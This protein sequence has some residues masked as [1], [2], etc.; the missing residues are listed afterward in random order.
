M[1]NPTS[2]SSDDAVAVHG[3]RDTSSVIAA[4][5]GHRPSLPLLLLAAALLLVAWGTSG[6]GPWP[7]ATTGSLGDAIRAEIRRAEAASRARSGSG[8]GRR[9]LAGASID[10]HVD[11]L[12]SILDSDEYVAAATAEEYNPHV[13]AAPERPTALRYSIIDALTEL[14]RRGTHRCGLLVYDPRADSFVGLLRDDGPLDKRAFAAA[15]GLAQILRAEFPDRF[16]PGSDEFAVPFASLEYPEAGPGDLPLAGAAPVL[17]FGTVHLD[18]GA[19]PNLVGMPTP[20]AHLGCFVRYSLVGDVCDYFARTPAPADDAAATGWEGM[21]PTVFWRGGETGYL[22]GRII[23][24][25]LV[26]PAGPGRP[27]SDME[28][29]VRVGAGRETTARGAKA[30]ATIALRGHYDVLLPRWKGTVLTAEAELVESEPV[31]FDVRFADKD[32]GPAGPYADLD[33]GNG[34]YAGPGEMAR[35]RYHIDLAGRSGT[36]W[37]GTWTRLGMPGLLFHHMTPMRDYIHQYMRP[38]VHYVPVRR[39]LSDLRDKYDAMEADPALAAKIARQATMLRGQYATPEGFGRLHRAAVVGPLRDAI[40]SYQPVDSF[41]RGFSWTDIVNSPQVEVEFADPESGKSA[42][43]RP[44]VVCSGD[45]GH[46]R[47]YCNWYRLK[48]RGSID[49]AAHLDDLA[50]SRRR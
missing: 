21:T 3:E 25:R 43:L 41:A 29:E 4:G 22:D 30:A 49:L 32:G 19:Y 13:F 50:R 34:T 8:G 42:A 26:R 27:G 12:M 36:T 35:Y 38:W 6:V 10:D 15:V 24:P 23:R 1:T 9:R 45:V 17:N 5:R 48:D 39:D 7:E 16:A 47:D 2:P 20:G 44:I 11:E 31:P 40:R 46:D 28:D 33:I 37:T 18:P 14:G